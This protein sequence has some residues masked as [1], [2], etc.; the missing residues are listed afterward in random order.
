MT[1]SPLVSVLVPSYNHEH[2]I[3]RAIESVVH[4]TYRPIQ[5]I[6]VDD[7]S[8]DQSRAII[9]SLQQ[10]YGFELVLQANKGLAPTLTDMLKTRVRGTYFSICSSDDFWHETKIE[11]QVKL[12]EQNPHFG[13]CYTNSY[14]VDDNHAIIQHPRLYNDHKRMRG[15]ELF[16]DLFLLHYHP[17]VSYLYRMDVLAELQFFPEEVYCEDFYMYLKIAARYPIG[18]IAEP[19]IYYRLHAISAAKTLKIV[20]SQYA[21][22]SEYADHPLYPRAVRE[23][24]LRAFSLYVKH[25]ELKKNCCEFLTDFNLMSNIRYWK[26]LI[27]YILS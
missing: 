1:D 16:A 17:P 15:G 8:T 25:K 26:S 22:L 7:G 19:L 2:F 21:I 12:M 11:Q 6:V 14:Y 27:R 3:A 20:A 9:H 23:W 4:Q 18:Y 5:L 13:M 10:Q 24:K